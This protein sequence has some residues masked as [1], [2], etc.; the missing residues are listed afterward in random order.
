MCLPHT[1]PLA[2]PVVPYTT[3]QWEWDQAKLQLKTPLRELCESISTR[4]TSVDDELKLKVTETNALKASLQAH[5]RKT[6]GNLMVRGLADLVSEEDVMDSEYMMTTFV[7]VPKASMK[8][9]ETSYETMAKYVVPK[10]G[11]VG[12]AP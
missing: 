3:M 6:Q 9:F 7:V 5:E 4:L 2:V 10:S 1:R 8:D 11:K 12:S